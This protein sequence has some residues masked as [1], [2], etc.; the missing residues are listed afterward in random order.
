MF[1]EYSGGASQP[2]FALFADPFTVENLSHL[3]ISF[4][5]RL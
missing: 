2:Y 3:S 1:I 5:P 4:H